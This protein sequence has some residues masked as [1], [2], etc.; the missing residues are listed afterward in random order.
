[1]NINDRITS[2]FDKINRQSYDLT[3]QEILIESYYLNLDL[4]DSET[5]QEQFAETMINNY[6]ESIS[7]LRVND[8]NKNLF[9]TYGKI[10]EEQLPQEIK[11]K[12]KEFTFDYFYH[13]LKPRLEDNLLKLLQG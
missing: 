2:T 7:S 11:T 12:G 9:F 8:K 3:A 10:M 5:V 13:Q 6:Y 4:L 1:M